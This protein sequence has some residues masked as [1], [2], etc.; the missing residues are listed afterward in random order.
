MIELIVTMAIA[1]ILLTMA[2][3]SLFNMLQNNRLITQT[4]QFITAIN[5]ARSE[6]IKRSAIINITANAGGGGSN[7]WGLGWQVAV[8][9]P[10]TTLRVFQALDGSSTLDSTGGELAFVYS[11]NGR[12][13][14]GPYTLTLC[15]G[16][17]GETGRLITISATG[18]ASTADAA[19]P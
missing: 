2:V 15:D 19:C 12:V 16:R 10:A 17:T 6:A 8:N 3:P 13:T 1:T 14:G 7:E 18:R 11:G 5:F 4:N 9:T